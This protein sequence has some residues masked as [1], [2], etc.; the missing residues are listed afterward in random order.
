MRA[1]EDGDTEAKKRAPACERPGGIAVESAG[2]YVTLLQEIHAQEYQAP[3]AS[4]HTLIRDVEGLYAGNWDSH[5]PCQVSY[6]TMGHVLEVALVTARM[7]AGWNRVQALEMR[8]SSDAFLTAMA[9]ALFHDAGYLKDKGD[10]EGCGGKHTFTH[11]DRSIAMAVGYLRT[12]G[13]DPSGVELVAETIR[14]TDFARPVVFGGVMTEFPGM[15]IG[16]MVGSSDLI[17]Q[18]ADVHYIERLPD[19]YTEFEEAYGCAGR[20]PLR[21]QGVKV[22]DSVLELMEGSLQFFLRLVLPRLEQMGNMYRFLS[23]YH[24]GERNPYMESIVANL[25]GLALQAPD[26]RQRLGEMLVDRGAITPEILAAALANQQRETKARDGAEAPDTGRLIDDWASRPSPDHRLG[27]VLQRMGE[28]PASALRQVVEEQVL[29]GHFLAALYPGDGSTL[30]R[31]GMMMGDLRR[32]PQA[33]AQVLEWVNE[34]VN[35]QASS[36]LLPDR[37]RERLVV[38][39]ASGSS[40][41]RVLGREMPLDVGVAGWVLTHARLAVVSEA[42]CD[43]RFFR[44]MDENTGFQT[45]SILALPLV[46]DEKVLGVLEV[47]NT[48]NGSGRFEE[49][50]QAVLAIVAR[51]LARSLD[52]FLWMVESG[53]LAEG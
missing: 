44:G 30:L 43:P 22:F 31:I 14:V 27:E 38:V 50:D 12:R 36:V 16:G 17:A 19:L 4:L 40:R 53:R 9:A 39:A 25:N 18:M 2:K 6:H 52:G 33:M 42:A 35:C 13:W 24:G 41:Q 49:R 21:A 8:L 15:V 48:Q 26:P 7:V 5:E 51:Q 46:V 20:D 23:A 47:L 28:V 1:N 37:Q 32:L 29:P 11:V 10:P 3:S 45:H 34:L